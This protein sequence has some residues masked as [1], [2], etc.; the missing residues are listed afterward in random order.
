MI[1]STFNNLS[2]EKRERIINAVIQE[3]A[4]HPADKVSINKII[5]KADI[6]R[7]SFYQYFDDKVDLIEIIATTFFENFY[8][9]AKEILEASDGDVFFMYLRFFDLTI[10]ISVNNEKKAVIKNLLSSLKANEDIV[11]EY[12]RNRIKIP[13]DIENI[14]QYVDRS[15]LAFTSDFDVKCLLGILNQLFKNAIF[16]LFVVETDS[17]IIREKFA[18]KIEIIKAGALK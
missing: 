8:N 12:L 6:S 2:K 16:E 3:F 11:S 15:K 4:Q 14:Y 9:K 17:E 10:S 1:K 7:G 18:R 13:I 5:Q